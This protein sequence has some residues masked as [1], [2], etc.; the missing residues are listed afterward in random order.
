MGDAE[1]KGFEVIDKRKRAKK[2]EA[3]QPAAEPAEEQPSGPEEQ[4]EPKAEEEPKEEQPVL[5]D[6]YSLIQWMI[7]MLSRE[8]LATDGAAAKPRGQKRF[9]KTWHRPRPRSIA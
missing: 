2:R 6:V 8:R 1:D 7:A 3:E 5:L 9:T 4:Q